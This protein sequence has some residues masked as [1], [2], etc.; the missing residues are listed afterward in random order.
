[1]S[2]VFRK[3]VPGR[4]D[5]NRA[6]SRENLPVMKNLYDK[7]ERGD[8]YQFGELITAFYNLEE[9]S[10]KAWT[11][12]IKDFYPADIQHEIERTVAAAMEHKDEKGN[13]CP[14]PI[15]FD[16]VSSEKGGGI[17][18]GVRV[19]YNPLS[20]HYYIEIIGYPSPPGSALK[21]R[22]TGIAPEDDDIE[23]F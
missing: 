12:E 16:W 18:R 2:L 9:A 15:R 17:G 1:M 3:H 22:Q 7:L 19:T 6:F 5:I 10:L 21:R 4:T 14:I 20:P 8:G 23:D 11:H 13:A